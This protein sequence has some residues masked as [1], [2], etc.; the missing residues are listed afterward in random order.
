MAIKIEEKQIGE[1]KFTVY[2]LAPSKAMPLMFK[3]MNIAGDS[4]KEI[5]AV[6]K[7]ESRSEE[8]EMEALI[9]A[10][11]GLFKRTTPEDL[12]EIIKSAIVDAT[13]CDGKVITSATYDSVFAEN[14]MDVFSVFAFVM[15]INFSD[16]MQGLG[17]LGLSGNLRAE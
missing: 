12:S 17:Q 5:T 9:K 7:T 4:I 8:E 2:Q 1:R 15:K 14:M 16:F 10:V 13:Y 6:Y 11:Q 3:V